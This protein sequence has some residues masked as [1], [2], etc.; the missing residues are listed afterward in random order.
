MCFHTIAVDDKYIFTSNIP[1]AYQLV[2]NLMRKAH[3]RKLWDNLTCTK[4]YFG[5][6]FPE[7]NLQINV[8]LCLKI[9]FSVNFYGV[10]DGREQS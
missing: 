4:G 5:R 1:S 9:G 3:S 2:D 6:L 8:I 10:V 7:K